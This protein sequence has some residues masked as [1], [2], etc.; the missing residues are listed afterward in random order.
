M[1]KL[2][3]EQRVKNMK[4]VKSKG[5]KIETALSKS[6]WERGIRYRK[7]V[8][9]IYGHPDLVLRRYNIVVFVDSEFWHGKDWGRRKD[10]IKSNQEFWIKKIERNIQR[11]I[12]VNNKLKE[13][14]W[15][16]IRFWGKEIE[17]NLRH[18]TD[19]LIGKID[20]FTTGN[21]D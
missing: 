20:E 1:D 13:D 12:E 8:K 9:S 14:G 16:V 5:S 17:K 15:Q 7:N 18:C 2:T 21:I 4:A 3:K 11:D 19:I 10:D 6:L